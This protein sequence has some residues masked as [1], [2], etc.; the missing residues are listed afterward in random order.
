MRMK[1]SAILTLGFA[2]AATGPLRADDKSEA[3]AIVNKAIEA[4]GGE[5]E[6]KKAQTSTSKM[7][8]TVHVMGLDIAFAG[9]VWNQGADRQRV[10]L[11]SE[12]MGQKFKI[13]HVFNR[14]KGW[15]K[16]NDK[17][18]EMDKDKVT[19]AVE[20]AHAALVGTLTPLKGKDYSLA[21]GG[22]E[23]VMDREAV[24]VLVSRKDRRDIKLF[25]D[26]KTQLLVKVEMRVKDEASGQEVL[27]ESFLSDF[28][29]KAPKQASKVAVK[30][31]GKPY[32]EA[33]IS[34]WKAEDKFDDS[35]FDKP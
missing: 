31:D 5:A 1:I 22:D 24:A 33:E 16:L 4:H 30:R 6:L 10:D 23:K 18:M 12:I 34:D 7:K 35:L 29:D 8:G 26:K 21:A 25:F 14:D 32:L 15:I 11:D 17:A 3:L 9:D 20:G 13:I 27:Q 2:F 28:S 19:E